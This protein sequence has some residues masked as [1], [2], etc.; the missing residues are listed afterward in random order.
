VTPPQGAPETTVA[1][2]AELWHQ[3]KPILKALVETDPRCVPVL[4]ACARNVLQE[5][6]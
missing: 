1:Q 5:A 3:A 2:D 4:V 6:E